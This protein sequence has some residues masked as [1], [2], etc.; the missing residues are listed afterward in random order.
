MLTFSAVAATELFVKIEEGALTLE[1]GGHPSIEMRLDTDD[2]VAYDD[3]SFRQDGSRVALE[4]NAAADIELL[5]PPQPRSR[6]SLATATL[7]SKDS[8]ALY[9]RVPM[10]ATSRCA[11]GS[12]L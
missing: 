3:I 12:N 1:G 7:R 10:T 8:T 5:V 2:D 11:A 9:K 6:C 4:V